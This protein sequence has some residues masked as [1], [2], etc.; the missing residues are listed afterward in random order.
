MNNDAALKLTTARYFTP[1]GRSIQAEGIVPDILIDKVKLSS[2]EVSRSDTVTEANLTGH[3]E[4]HPEQ[5][6]KTK[7]DPEG[8]AAS[9]FELF[10]ALNLLK[11]MNILQAR[12]SSN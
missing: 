1:S 5:D 6:A 9:D 3:L 2:I 10:E 11:G 7:N 4:N 8:L 12:S